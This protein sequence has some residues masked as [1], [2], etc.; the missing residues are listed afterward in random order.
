[1]PGLESQ[2]HPQSYVSLSS[3]SLGFRISSGLNS[4]LSPGWALGPPPWASQVSPTWTLPL[5]LLPVLHVLPLGS[6]DCCDLPSQHLEGWLGLCSGLLPVSRLSSPLL[7]PLPPS[8]VLAATSSVLDASKHLYLGLL[9][10]RFP[11]PEPSHT[12]GL[13]PHLPPG[14]SPVP[15][16]PCKVPRTCPAF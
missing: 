6:S 14:P 5:F 11:R 10:C 3:P 1:M 4:L 8:S 16:P 13:K 12:Q 9:P 15:R 7:R 2:L